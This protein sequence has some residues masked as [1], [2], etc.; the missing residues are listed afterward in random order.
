MAIKHRVQ[1]AVTIETC[2]KL[3]GEIKKILGD[4]YPD[5]HFVRLDCQMWVCLGVDYKNEPKA[6][7]EHVWNMSGKY[8]VLITV[9]NT[10]VSGMLPVQ[11][12]KP[13]E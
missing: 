5:L 1:A 3:A 4:K 7:I 9:C 11:R 6:L 13:E 2:A 12:V 8:G 10:L